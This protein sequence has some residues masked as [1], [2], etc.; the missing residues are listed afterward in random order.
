ML[1]I[2]CEKEDYEILQNILGHYVFYAFGS[3]VKG[4]HCRFSDLD[5]CYKN[6]IPDEIVADLKH[7]LEESNLSF[8]VEMINW[9]RCTQAFKHSIEQDL[10]LLFSSTPNPF[11]PHNPKPSGSFPKRKSEQTL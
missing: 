4:T 6:P 2:H 1:Q 5:L 7:E 11:S 3:R 8:K 9:Q 10:V